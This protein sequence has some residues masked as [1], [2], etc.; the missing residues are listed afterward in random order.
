MPGNSF[1]PQPG[2]AAVVIGEP[3]QPSGDDWEAAVQ[4]RDQARAFVVNHSGEMDAA[5]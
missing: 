3:L 5:A 4:L 2:C 1:F